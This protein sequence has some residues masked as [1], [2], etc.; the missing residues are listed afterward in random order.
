MTAAVQCV[1]AWCGST[2]PVLRRASRI[3]RDSAWVLE[4]DPREHETR[5][6]LADALDER[7]EMLAPDDADGEDDEVMHLRG[8]VDS[9]RDQ[10]SHLTTGDAQ[11]AALAQE[12]IGRQR[13]EAELASI[14]ARVEALIGA[15]PVR[16][17]RLSDMHARLHDRPGDLVGPREC[18]RPGCQFWE[19]AAFTL[20]QIDV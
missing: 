2:G 20:E 12:A 13:A 5:L 7:A 16:H 9:M 6:G 19:M 1:D 18:D 14:K 3:L 11:V 10:L 8:L 4:L 17:V 15:G